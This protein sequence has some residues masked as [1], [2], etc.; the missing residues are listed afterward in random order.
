M[1][2]VL[3]RCSAAA[4]RFVKT[5]F[6]SHDHSIRVLGSASSLGRYPSSWHQFFHPVSL[7]IFRVLMPSFVSVL[8]MNVKDRAAA[9]KARRYGLE[10]KRRWSDRVCRNSE[11]AC[12]EANVFRVR[13]KALTVLVASSCVQII[14]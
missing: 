4:C 9:A 10:I 11:E 1:A 2:S 14:L 3:W 7:S 13:C 12:S 8:F 5:E 6:M